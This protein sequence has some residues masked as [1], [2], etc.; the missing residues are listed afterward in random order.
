MT[1]TTLSL[2]QTTA[3]LRD[4]QLALNHAIENWSIYSPIEMAVLAVEYW[5]ARK[6][7][8]DAIIGDSE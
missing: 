7:F 8:R 6:A 1:A 2:A 4:A 3:D 5:N